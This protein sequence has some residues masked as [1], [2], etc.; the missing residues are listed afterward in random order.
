MGPSETNGALKSLRTSL[1]LHTK[2][3]QFSKYWSLAGHPKLGF[4]VLYFFILF[5]SGVLL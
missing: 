3:D 1:Q 4:G 2:S 5:G